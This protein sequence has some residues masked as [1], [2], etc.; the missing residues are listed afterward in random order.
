MEGKKCFVKRYHGGVR[1]KSHT[2]HTIKQDASWNFY[3]GPRYPF[4]TPD[5]CS[6]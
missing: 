1:S 4:Q 2:D 5:M 3:V 6:V